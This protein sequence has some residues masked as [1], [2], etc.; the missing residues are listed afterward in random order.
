MHSAIMFFFAN[1]LW[2]IES[3]LNSELVSKPYK[4]GPLEWTSSR[5]G[6]LLMPA[7]V[8]TCLEIIL[9][10]FFCIGRIGG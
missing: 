4:K 10:R 2:L 6:G 9:T 3:F 8:K 7:L 5:G 1:F